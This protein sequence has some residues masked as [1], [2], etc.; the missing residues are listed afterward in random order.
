MTFYFKFVKLI[1]VINNKNYLRTGG[2]IVILHGEDML[3]ETEVCPL[4]GNKDTL[5][6]MKERILSLW[7]RTK[8]DDFVFLEFHRDEDGRWCQGCGRSLRR[9][10]CMA[11]TQPRIL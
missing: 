11:V 4:C 3:G 6:F 8:E 5:V 1:K 2:G 7:A 10:C 9:V